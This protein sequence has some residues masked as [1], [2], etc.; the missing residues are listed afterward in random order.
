MDPL[1]ETDTETVMTGQADGIGSQLQAALAA[2][3]LD[4]VE[5]EYPHHRQSVES[6]E[7][8]VAHATT[9]R[10]FSVASTGTLRFT[11]TGV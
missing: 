2:H 4:C 3:P 5:T 7:T 6:S 1:A 11:A 9:T 10:S 8:R